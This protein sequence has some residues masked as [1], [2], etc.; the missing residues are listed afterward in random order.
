V[1]VADP[2]RQESG[3]T[4]AREVALSALLILFGTL[5]ALALGE[6]FLELFV[7]EKTRFY[8]WPP[9]LRYT[10]QISSEVLP[11]VTE[12]ESHFISNSE[13][14]RGPEF[15]G[16]R[17]SEYR[18]L[19]V[20]G[21]TTECLFLDQ[22]KAWPYL[23]GENLSKTADGRK[24]W[25]G[26]IGRSGLN[27]R[28][29]ILEM[30]YLLPYYDVD[31]L[32]FLIGVNDLGLLLEQGD[33]YDPIYLSEEEHVWRQ[34]K[35]AFLVIPPGALPDRPFYEK[36]R[37]FR[38][39]SSLAAQEQEEENQADAWKFYVFGRKNRQE[40]Q[41]IEQL[42]SLASALD[43]YERNIR[44]IVSL[45]EQ[46][47]LRMVFATQP[48]LW[49]ADITTEEESLLWQGWARRPRKRPGDP[50][51]SVEA[52]A[53]GMAAYNE[54]LLRLCM[55]YGL[56]CVDL[57]REL[58]KDLTIFYDDGHYNENGARETARV[59]A[60]YFRQRPPFTPAAETS[61]TAGGKEECCN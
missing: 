38:L 22:S 42:P 23:L 7:P 2:S 33:E 18:I 36:T 44:E 26:N 12:G 57:A 32:V 37:L 59:L 4:R 10:F 53:S 21:S 47:G 43:E 11:G 54:R 8:V 45:G 19:A 39:A 14:I 16:E 6:L 31:V 52:L 9:N 41:I 24:V 15:S 17:G 40:G 27:T 5:I 1:T 13:G 56:E 51:Y 55:K 20:G 3:R 49:K 58:P 30:K 48:T 28:D 60:S 61:G 46:Q 35:H 25:V 50:Y 29:H 34:L